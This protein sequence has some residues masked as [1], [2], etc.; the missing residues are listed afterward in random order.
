MTTDLITQRIPI[1]NAKFL[2]S[3]AQEVATKSEAQVFIRKGLTPEDTKFAEGERASIDRITTKRVDRDG[4]IV[5][6]QGAILDDYRKHPIV[7]WAHKYDELGLGRNMWIKADDEGLIAKTEYATHPKAQ[8]VYEYRK[9]GFPLAKSIGFIPLEAVEQKDFDSVDLKSLGLTKEEVQGAKRIYTKWILLEYSDVPIPSN[10]DALQIAISKGLIDR[11]EALTFYGPW[12]SK[13]ELVSENLPWIE[14][15][16]GLKKAKDDDVIEL[17]DVEEISEKISDDVKEKETVTKPETTDNYHR[18]PVPAEEGKHSGHKIRTIDISTEQGI[19]ALYCVDCKKNITYLFDINI[20]SMEEARQWVADHTKEVKND[21]VEEKT[22]S[23]AKD[24]P[25]DQT[26]SWDA[27]AAEARIRKWAGGPNKENVDWSKYGKA[28]VVVDPANKENFTGYKLPFADVIGGTLK[29]TRGGVINAMRAV[30]GAR[31]GVNLSEGERKAAYNFLASYYKRFDMEPPEYKTAD[32]EEEAIKTIID[33]LVKDI[34]LSKYEVKKPEYKER[35]NKSL[36]EVFDV[37]AVDVPASSFVYELYSKYLG[38]K[39]KDVYSNDFT[40]PSP[41]MGTYLTAYKNLVEQLQVVDIRNFSD[42]GAESPLVYEVVQL[43]SSTKDDFLIQGMVFA[44]SVDGFPVVVRYMPTWFGI[45]VSVVTASKFRKWNAK[46][47]DGAHVWAKENNFL[48]GEKFAL[49][50][51]FI[52]KSFEGWDDLVIDKSLERKLKSS[53]KVF[54]EA[55]KA[56]KSRGLLMV[57]PP[58]TGKTLTGKILKNSTDH[59]FIWVSSK[60]LNKVGAVRG[61]E[62][63]Y[64]LARDL[65]PAIIFMEDIDSWLHGGV[66]DLLKTEM[67]GLKSNGGIMTILTSNHPEQLPDALLDRPG[68]FHDILNYST[69]NEDTRKRMIQRWVGEVDPDVIEDLAKSTEGF[70]GAHMRELIEFAEALH[71]D[72]QELSKEDA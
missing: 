23:G 57:G 58:G 16:Y 65:S 35:W 24:L 21:Q 37:Q 41:L 22:I 29:A 40:I 10:P 55:G 36:S 20:W 70:S 51:E 4:E 38:C 64:S 19:K 7:L 68:R 48:K 52:G 61:V 72:D 49:N 62:L 56:L 2:P 46:Q 39:I 60:D 17:I 47:V 63:A 18:V 45:K 32:E 9:A 71:E 11:E 53:I 42:Y 14:E 8:E 44:K 26:T 12:N 54:N 5:L 66:I 25:L 31:G 3:W 28:F 43:N 59:T 27:A 50:G 34:D 69:P 13:G 15:R 6:P 1:G 30:L 33:E 67:D